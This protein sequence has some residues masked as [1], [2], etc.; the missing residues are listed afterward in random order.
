VVEGFP[1][2]ALSVQLKEEV[3]MRY[4]SAYGIP[5][6]AALTLVVS[7]PTRLLA[8]EEYVV[9]S[10]DPASKGRPLDKGGAAKVN[11]WFAGGAWRLVVTSNTE[12]AEGKTIQGEWHG[13]IVAL[14][15]TS[16]LER[17]K[18][19]E[20]RAQDKTFKDR[21]QVK[22][23]ELRFTST[24]VAG[25][26]GIVFTTDGTK[27]LF[28]IYESKKH[29]PASAIFI[30]GKGE[31]PSKVPFVLKVPDSPKRGKQKEQL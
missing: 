27:V 23:N 10:V 31:N 7:A 5:V 12:N 25:L 28:D 26:D 3:T 29:V 8:E 4:V 13:R 24:T 21:A 17:T 11:I 16:I 18:A 20:S 1:V 30:G 22:G 15:G 9:E 6:L 14:D 2:Q 19:M